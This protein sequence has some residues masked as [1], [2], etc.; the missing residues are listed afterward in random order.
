MPEQPKFS[1]EQLCPGRAAKDLGEIAM[2]LVP[3]ETWLYHDTQ[4][5]GRQVE[6][7]DAATYTAWR[8][9]ATKKGPEDPY[10]GIE[11]SGTRANQDVKDMEFLN[12]KVQQEGVDIDAADIRRLQEVVTRREADHQEFRDLRAEDKLKAV[13]NTRPFLE[14]LAVIQH[15]REV[16]L[17]LPDDLR[18]ELPL[19]F[20]TPLA[21][22]YRLDQLPFM[23]AREALQACG[24]PMLLVKRRWFGWA[25][26]ELRRVCP[27]G[28]HD[29]ADYL[30]AV[31]QTHQGERHDP[32]RQ[33]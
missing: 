27:Y 8:Y 7:S 2:Q 13:V 24:G 14:Q 5:P 20:D 26:E 9:F 30:K 33:G 6:F 10:Y 12:A 18:E 17:A 32:R 4:T 25:Q 22:A 29:A 23:V 16:Y 19:R 31:Y 21:R 28:N 1:C 3:L 11:L 15:E